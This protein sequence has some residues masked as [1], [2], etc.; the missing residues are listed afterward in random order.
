MYNV[1]ISTNPDPN[2]STNYLTNADGLP[3]W[4]WLS[5]SSFSK[6][7]LAFLNDRERR[8]EYFPG[9]WWDSRLTWCWWELPQ[10]GCDCLTRSPSRRCWPWTRRWRR[11]SLSSS[12]P[13]TES[14]Q[15]VCCSSVWTAWW[16][17]RSSQTCA[18]LC[19][20]SSERG[21]SLKDIGD[22]MKLQHLG[23]ISPRKVAFSKRR[24][25]SASRISANSLREH[26]ISFTL[27]ISM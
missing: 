22:E 6:C 3:C 18:R 15:P 12:P 11:R 4:S 13:W 9:S 21:I 24:T 23:N 1:C 14:W 20:G 5:F 10:Q 17:W 19:V 7:F 8:L 27:G 2:I 25:S 26:S 16:C